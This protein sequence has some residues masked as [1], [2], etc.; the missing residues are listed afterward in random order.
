MIRKSIEQDAQYFVTIKNQLP[1]PFDNQS[2]QTGG[3]L[4]GTNIDT[5]KFYIKNGNCLTATTNNQI[6]GFGIVLPNRFVKNSD[7]WN[8]RK[9]VNWTIDLMDLENSNISFIEQLA[10]LKG[11]NRSSMLLAYHLAKSAFDND[12]EFLLTT[13]VVKPIFNSAA[14]PYINVIG[15]IKIGNIDEVY[16]V[17]GAIN[18]DIY[19]IRKATFFESVKNLPFYDFLESSIIR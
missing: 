2:T 16:P 15:G 8:K 1:L 3:F 12:T 10:F 13:T 14:I 6:I 4:L 18:S 17:A 9:S 5:Y 19:L 11:H 7:L